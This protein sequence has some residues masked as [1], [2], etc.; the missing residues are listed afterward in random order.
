MRLAVGKVLVTWLFAKNLNLQK[1]SRPEQTFNDKSPTVETTG[2]IQNLWNT[3][4]GRVIK[5]S[6]LI[7]DLIRT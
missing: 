7:S 4:E 5:S 3:A 1:I 6:V 2:D